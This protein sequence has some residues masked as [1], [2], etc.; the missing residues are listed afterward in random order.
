MFHATPGDVLVPA[1]AAGV[2]SF[3]SVSVALVA[4]LFVVSVMVMTKVCVPNVH[5]VESKVNI[6][7][8]RL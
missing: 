6:P 3:D 7:F 2:V 8:V 4:V 5:V 1:A